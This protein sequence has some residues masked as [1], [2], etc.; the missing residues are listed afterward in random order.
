M[1]LNKTH[2][3]IRDAIA[4]RDSGGGEDSEGDTETSR[5][6]ASE[7]HEESCWSHLQLTVALL[8]HP[9]LLKS[10]MTV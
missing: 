2:R 6:Q 10:Q 7:P 8:N 5:A 9:L 1:F 4:E 3:V